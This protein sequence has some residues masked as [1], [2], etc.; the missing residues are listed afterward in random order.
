MFLFIIMPEPAAKILGSLAA[1]VV[2]LGDTGVGKST[3]LYDLVDPCVRGPRRA[4]E[5]TIGVDFVVKAQAL[6]EAENNSWRK[7]KSAGASCIRL[8]IWDVSG[9]ERFE[10]LAL[11]YLEGSKLVVVFY[12]ITSRASFE[13]VEHW[14]EKVKAAFSFSSDA[15]DRTAADT[16]AAAA[17]PQLVLVG[18]K[19]N[20]PAQR[21]VSFDEGKELAERHGFCFFH[22]TSAA[23][24]WAP[25]QAPREKLGTQKPQQDE[26]SAPASAGEL[27]AKVAELLDCSHK[28][29]TSPR[30]AQNGAASGST[31]DLGREGIR[32]QRGS[33][34]SMITAPCNGVF[35][36]PRALCRCFGFA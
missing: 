9:K 35:F 11:S 29:L 28:R 15:E 23:T 33:W 26:S 8:H 27:F 7:G 1:K 12:S 18:T 34:G 6:K 36:A 16:M 17:T 10:P 2:L 31:H 20:L 3:L 13:R 25:E 19:A 14:V 5:P 22:E 21:E 32:A 4:V 24:P 30:E